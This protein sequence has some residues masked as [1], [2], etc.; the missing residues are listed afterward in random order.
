MTL[1]SLRAFALCLVSML[2]LTRPLFAWESPEHLHL[3]DE[4]AAA[5]P[6]RILLQAHDRDFPQRSLPQEQWPTTWKTLHDKGTTDQQRFLRHG[7]TYG[8]VVAL[9]GD[10][11]VNFPTLSKA[12]LQEVYELIPLIRDDKTS[13]HTFQNTTGHRYLALA[14]ENHQHFRLAKSG[15]NNLD[16]WAHFHEKAIQAARQA[17]PNEA[18]GISAAAA[19]FLTDAFSGGHLRVP[20]FFLMQVKLLKL[21]IGQVLSKILHDLDNQHG[22]MVINQRGD[23]AWLAYGDGLLSRFDNYTNREKMREV[24]RLCLAA[25]S[26]ALQQGPSYPQDKVQQLA[27]TVRS[28][29]PIPLSNIDVSRWGENPDSRFMAALNR[30]HDPTGILNK[31]GRHVVRPLITYELAQLEIAL[32]EIPGLL[33]GWIDGDRH[34]RTWVHK[35]SE[36]VLAAQ[37]LSEKRRWIE[38][39]TS[40]YISDDDGTAVVKICRSVSTLFEKRELLEK[41]FRSLFT[42]DKNIAKAKQSLQAN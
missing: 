36:A 39:L 21:H 32:R 5:Y 26:E 30:I 23:T 15:E 3:G 11:Y 17:K 24:L 1:C 8:E 34:I 41:N 7:L 35:H 28:I 12:S 25:V 37:P 40:G 2:L 29:A 31:I 19:H 4:A 14:E 22:V 16:M 42:L 20:R 6:V 27:Q 10:F 9:V 33:S 18:W 13:T 38:R